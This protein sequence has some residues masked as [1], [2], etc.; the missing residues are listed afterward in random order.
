VT[1]TKIECLLLTWHG[2]LLCASDSGGLY[3]KPLTDRE[4]LAPA[5]RLTVATALD[6]D[7]A[8]L[9]PLPDQAPPYESA[10]LGEGVATRAGD[11]RGF[12]FS[13][14]A[15]FLCA[16]E[17]AADDV[18]WNR[19]LAGPWERFLPVPVELLIKLLDLRTRDWIDR[20]N[21]RRIAGRAITF[22][23]N[24]MFSMGAIDSD[25]S[26]SF[27][28]FQSASRE[29]ARDDSS[30]LFL[31]GF[32]GQAAEFVSTREP[33]PPSEEPLWLRAEH[34]QTAGTAALSLDA[35]ELKAPEVLYYPPT[36]AHR[37]DRKFFLTRSW[38]RRPRLGYTTSRVTVRQAHDCHLMLYRTLEGVVF[39]ADGVRRGYGFLV[40]GEHLP[41]AL[42][43]EGDRYFID[44]QSID[45][46]PLLAGDY[47]V[48]YNG[49]LH[50]YYHWL[51]EAILSLYM[52]CKIPHEG[53]AI[54]LPAALAKISSLQFFESLNLLGFGELK[55]TLCAA[56]LV[57]LERAR[58][59]ATL[60]DPLED[61]P[62]PVLLEFQSFAAASVPRGAGNLRLY[63]ERERL[64]TVENAAEV[65][66][67]LERAGF[68]TI[69][70][71]GMP[72]A[73]QV[74]L[75]ADAEFVVGPHGAGLANLLFTPP[76]ARVIEFMPAA[77]M[78]PFFWLISSK[79]G[80]EYGMLRCDTDNGK[81]NGKL[82]VDVQKLAR[83]LS[84]LEK[85]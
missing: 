51:V 10:T 17:T 45:E 5:C 60:N 46:A 83:M 48:F 21:G 32:G 72:F 9:E 24:F 38:N 54:V 61:F 42:Q 37:D 85:A 14:G 69:R 39:D 64:R 41:K 40:A 7:A 63:V 31:L 20:S 1:E 50:N 27:P 52:L 22:R 44:R 6:R 55:Q 8:A 23:R 34:Q 30:S 16:P 74:R 49:N 67:F 4:C 12:Y 62:E 82:R 53:S 78:R 33:A 29:M 26:R 77:Q 71:E 2:T 56:P 65:R 11:G 76:S 47:L 79:L 35:P 15:R 84:L 59:I 57:R 68:V 43:K 18:G 36:F 81:F 75:F 3:Q 28:S 25:L 58:W 13:R 73:E 70:L 66:E 19:E 80:H